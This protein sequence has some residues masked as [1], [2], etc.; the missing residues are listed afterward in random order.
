MYY[1]FSDEMQVSSK[2]DR[3]QL[4]SQ[5]YELNNPAA[6]IPQNGIISKFILSE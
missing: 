2:E 4:L 3:E 5:L 1:C 6:N